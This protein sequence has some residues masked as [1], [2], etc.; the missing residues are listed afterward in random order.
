[1]LRRSRRGFTLLEILITL[2][3]FS[4]GVVAVAGLFGTAMTA[5]SDAESTALASN[6]VQERLEE[7]RNKDYLSVVNEAKAVVTAFPLYQRQVTVTESPTDLKRVRVNVYW[8]APG[9]ETSVFAETYVSK[10]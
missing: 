1:M 6:L 2:L 3:L 4:T 9:G 5:G 8:V 10:N 7:F